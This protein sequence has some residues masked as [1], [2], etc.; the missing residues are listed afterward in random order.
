MGASSTFSIVAK[1]HTHTWTKAIPKTTLP[2]PAPW[3]PAPPSSG[4]L[5][6]GV[7]IMWNRKLVSTL[8][9]EEE[10]VTSAVSA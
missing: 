3:L 10:Q 5:Q 7:W 2:F 8:L 1:W 4:Q 9:P 6:Q